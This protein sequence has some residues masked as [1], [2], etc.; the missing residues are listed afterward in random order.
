M[1]RRCAKR[2]SELLFEAI[3]LDCTPRIFGKQLSLEALP[4]ALS[5]GPHK[6]WAFPFVQAIQNFHPAFMNL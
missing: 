5:T 3:G 4:L 1:Q 2:S 6:V